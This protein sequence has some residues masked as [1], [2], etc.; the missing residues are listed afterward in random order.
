[1]IKNFETPDEIKL[2]SKVFVGSYY[3]SSNNS[4][5]IIVLKKIPLFPKISLKL[6][7][8]TITSKTKFFKKFYLLSII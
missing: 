7:S 1:M 2:N 5:Y 6:I 3:D 8:N 4:E